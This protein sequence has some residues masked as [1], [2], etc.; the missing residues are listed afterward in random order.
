VSVVSV[1]SARRS[2]H[3]LSDLAHAKLDLVQAAPGALRR[4]DPA[5]DSLLAQVSVVYDDLDRVHPIR[6]ATSSRATA[7]CYSGQLGAQG[8]VYALGEGCAYEPATALVRAEA[9]AYVVVDGEAH[10][11]G[12]EATIAVRPCPPVTLLEDHTTE[13]FAS[14][15]AGQPA[16]YPVLNSAIHDGPVSH[17]VAP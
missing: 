10:A 2:R 7:A 16:L 3:H 12:D 14:S 13:V 17:R 9:D 1:V 6:C 8:R 5:H 4:L 11:A 15:A